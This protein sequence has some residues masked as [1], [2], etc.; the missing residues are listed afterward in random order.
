MFAYIR[1]TPGIYP[2]L[3]G[4]SKSKNTAKLLPSLRGWG[5]GGPWLQMTSALLFQW[6]T[7]Y[8]NCTPFIH[9]SWH[10]TKPSTIETNI[11]SKRP[12]SK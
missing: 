4:Q 11:K 1:Q 2:A 7:L 6:A 12:V 8:G 10:Q 5:G 3:Q 9:D